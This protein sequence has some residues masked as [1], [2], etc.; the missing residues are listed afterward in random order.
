MKANLTT[1]FITRW[2]SYVDIIGSLSSTSKVI[3]SEKTPSHQVQFEKMTDQENW[4]R[5]RI[6]LKDIEAGTGLE[7]KVFSYLADVSWAYSR[8][9]RDK[10]P[11]GGEIT[12]NCYRRRFSG[13]DYEINAHLNE[14]ERGA[15]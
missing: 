2:F 6:N 8:E 7:A 14:S 5:R 3:T 10:M 4:S 9:N 1:Y 12:Q 11:T 15:R 13:L